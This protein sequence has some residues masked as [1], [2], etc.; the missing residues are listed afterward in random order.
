MLKIKLDE[1]F[2]RNKRLRVLIITELVLMFVL[3]IV[4]S[5]TNPEYLI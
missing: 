5:I 2:I 3:L 1:T 4:A